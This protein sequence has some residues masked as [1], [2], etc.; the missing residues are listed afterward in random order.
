MN[1]RGPV[2]VAAGGTGGHLFPAAALSHALAVRGFEVH[3]VTDERAAKYGGDFPAHTPFTDWPPRPRAEARLLP[4]SGR[5][6]TLIRRDLRAARRLFKRMKPRAVIGFGGYPT[7]PPVLAASWLGVPALLH[8]GN[9]VIGRANRYLADRVDVIAKGFEVLG[10]VPGKHGRE[11]A[12][13]RK[14]GPPDGDRGR[15]GG[16]PGLL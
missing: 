9:A 5:S 12:P 16:L 1:G 14:S 2:A 11:D 15:A 10:G 13:H 6:S 8:E 4:R 3:L 7:V